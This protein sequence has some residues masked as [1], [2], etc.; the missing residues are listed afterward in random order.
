MRI[1]KINTVFLPNA[2]VLLLACCN[3]LQAFAKDT[4]EPII[5][6]YFPSWS[7]NY[8]NTGQ[9]SKLRQIPSYINHIFLAFAKPDLVYEKS[10]YDLTGTGIQVPYDGCAL[11]ESI[12]A[13][14]DKGIKV[15]LSLG[16]ETYWHNSAVYENIKYHQIKDLVDD[17]GFSGID[18]DY[19]P[20]GSFANIGS[21]ENVGHFI[22]FINNSRALMPKS[23]GYLIACAPSGVGALGGQQNNDDNSPYAYQNRNVLTGENDDHLFNGSVQTNG[24]NLFGF[25]ATGHMIPVIESVGDKLDIIAYQGYNAG[26]SLN[27]TIMYDSFAYYGNKYGFDVV[28]GIHYPDEPWGPYYEYTHQN[29]ASL[30]R[31]IKEHKTRISKN[32]GIMIWHLLLESA[33][34]SSYSYLNVAS[35][36]LSGASESIAIDQANDYQISE[37]DGVWDGCDNENASF[38]GFPLYSNNKTYPNPNA[39]VYYSCRIWENKW[40]V[41]PNEIPGINEVWEEVSR[42]EENE[43]DKCRELDVIDNRFKKDKIDIYVAVDGSLLVNNNS[44][45]IIENLKIMN[46]SGKK[47]ISV[48]SFSRNNKFSLRERLATGIYFVRIQLTNNRVSYKKIFF[49]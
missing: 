18:W 39:K 22:D 16:G 48:S 36:V 42:C 5:L 25:S 12:S 9:N 6:A 11:K 4:D 33:N 40:Y 29:V 30:S 23:E 43:K 32:D 2:L 13:L 26:G 7:E 20:N 37:Y 10:S 38:C 46:V 19:E 1:I 17:F 35:K 15:I 28:A 24:I 3:F 14:N 45:D 27:R 21:P 44:D 41:N 31:H 49:R 8:A 34:N 47:I